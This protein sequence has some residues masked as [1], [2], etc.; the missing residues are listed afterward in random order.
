MRLYLGFGLDP[1]HRLSGHDGPAE[2]VR[3]FD[4]KSVPGSEALAGATPVSPCATY[5]NEDAWVDDPVREGVVLVVDAAMTDNE[6]A[7]LYA[8]GRPP[9][10][11]ATKPAR[12]MR[13]TWRRPC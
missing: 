13:N 12:P 4:L 11:A 8:A 1:R 5:P 3:A 6:I 9:A 7:E 2:F 10:D